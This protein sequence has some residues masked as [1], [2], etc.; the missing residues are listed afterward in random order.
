VLFATRDLTS[1]LTGALVALVGLC[2]AW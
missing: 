2:A 1:Y